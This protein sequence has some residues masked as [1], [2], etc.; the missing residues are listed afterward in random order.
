MTAIIRQEGPYSWKHDHTN[1]ITNIKEYNPMTDTP[2][3]HAAAVGLKPSKGRLETEIDTLNA[4]I[5]DLDMAVKRLWDK[6]QPIM[7]P[8]DPSPAT[9]GEDYPEMSA[10]AR[11]IREMADRALEIRGVLDTIH[12]RLEC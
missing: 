1:P 12:S 11:M 6:V 7:G 3:A 8:S 10:A 4:A 9:V 2:L 5:T